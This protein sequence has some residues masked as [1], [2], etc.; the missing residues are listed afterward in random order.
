MISR[1]S[2]TFLL[3]LGL[4][5]YLWNCSKQFVKIHINA[6]R[7]VLFKTMI[8][9]VEEDDNYSRDFFRVQGVHMLSEDV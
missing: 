6:K 5:G 1:W 9:E 7:L 2:P 8:L 3:G 4:K